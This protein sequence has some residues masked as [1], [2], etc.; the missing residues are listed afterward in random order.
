MVDFFVDFLGVVVYLSMM[1]K[2]EEI[3]NLSI[4]Y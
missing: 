4:I 2:V 1:V 3:M